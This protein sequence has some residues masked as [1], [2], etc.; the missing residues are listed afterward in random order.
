LWKALRRSTP[1]KT[2]TVTVSPDE[3]IARFIYRKSDL[4]KQPTPKPKP[5]VFRPMF[6]AGQ[7]ETSVCR[8][9]A[10]PEQ[11]IWEIVNRAH[12]PLPAL[13]RADLTANSVKTAGLRIDAAPDFEADYPEHAVII[14]WPDAKDKQMALSIQLA[15]AADLV[16][17]PI[18]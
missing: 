1:D 18:S 9:S 5:K 6:E 3:R 8:I 15:S 13:A 7:L 16:L 2:G 10:A 14:G 4:S 17:A 11:R 12:S